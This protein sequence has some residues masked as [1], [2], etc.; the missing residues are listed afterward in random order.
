MSQAVL[1]HVKEVWL[2][3]LSL[4]PDEPDLLLRHCSTFVTLSPLAVLRDHH[5]QASPYASLTK[6]E[7][8]FS[9]VTAQRSHPSSSSLTV[10]G[11]YIYSI[12][13]RRPR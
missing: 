12:M 2:L 4:L 8:E 5:H 6:Q 1:R 7:L 3:T 11:T 13:N 10:L 9:V